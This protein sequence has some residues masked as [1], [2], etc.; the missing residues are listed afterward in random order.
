MRIPYQHHHMLG[1][2]TSTMQLTCIP[3]LHTTHTTS[4]HTPH[5]Y[6]ECVVCQWS[7]MHILICYCV[8]F[9]CYA[10]KGGV[11]WIQRCCRGMCSTWASRLISGNHAYATAALLHCPWA[12]M[13][14][15]P[16]SEPGKLAF[17]WF[18]YGNYE[19][20]RINKAHVRYVACITL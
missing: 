13:R 17:L 8:V 3:S 20:H 7:T 12:L 1:L 4:Q 19:N 9:V 16:F 11:T 14:I 18:C 5:P 15:A 10:L 6:K 2:S